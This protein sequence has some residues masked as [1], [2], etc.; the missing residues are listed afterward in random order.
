MHALQAHA[1]YSTKKSHMNMDRLPKGFHLLEDSA[2]SAMAERVE[3][4]LS[5]LLGR[6]VP[7][8]SNATALVAVL[9]GDLLSLAV[10]L[11]S[12]KTEDEEEKSFLDACVMR[13]L[14][15]A[16]SLSEYERTLRQSTTSKTSILQKAN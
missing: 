13:L 2:P 1:N 4:V 10:R 9:R 12:H 3:R 6:T 14:E 11:D 8:S 15:E 5:P 7:S 16:N